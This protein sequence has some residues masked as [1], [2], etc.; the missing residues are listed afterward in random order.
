MV[1]K[2]VTEVR[3]WIQMMLLIVFG[4]YIVAMIEHDLERR[5]ILSYE[6][7]KIEYDHLQ[8]KRQEVNTLYPKKVPKQYGKEKTDAS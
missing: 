3:K 6:L 4:V 2:G 1:V 8:L 5:Y 7:G